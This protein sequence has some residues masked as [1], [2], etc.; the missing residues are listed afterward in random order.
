MFPASLYESVAF[1]PAIGEGQPH[2]L[3]WLPSIGCIFAPQ[4]P[5]A[6]SFAEGVSH[7]VKPLPDVR[8]SDARRAGIDRPDGVRLAFQVSVYSV[9]PSES[10]TAC[11]LL[12]S[13]NDRAALADESE[14]RGPQIALVIERF[15][16]TRCAE[17]L[18]GAA[19]S[20]N[21]VFVRPAGLA[22]G[23]TPHSDAGEEVALPVASEIVGSN[24]DN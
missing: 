24:I 19:S 7:P 16:L 8:A 22:E 2:S 3:T 10:E 20:P 23:V 14:E 5:A 11:N 18:A 6:S 1:V 17:W 9:E 15:S 21:F 4:F 13:D 12:A